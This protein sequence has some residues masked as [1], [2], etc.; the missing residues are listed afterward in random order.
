MERIIK[1]AGLEGAKAELF[2]AVMRQLEEHSLTFEEVLERPEDYADARAGVPGF[3]Y[4]LDTE[5][6]ATKNCHLITQVLFELESEIGPLEKD[7]QNVLNW[8]AWFALEWAI[9]IVMDYKGA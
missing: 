8:M 4:Y 5:P 1:W 9:G 7:T 2:R 3:I 6:F